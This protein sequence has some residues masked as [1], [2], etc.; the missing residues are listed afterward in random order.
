MTIVSFALG[1]ALKKGL[2]GEFCLRGLPGL[3]YPL[4]E[5]LAVE[6]HRYNLHPAWVGG[7]VVCTQAFCCCP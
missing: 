2:G 1:P 4:D 6:G 3:G 7:A 5:F